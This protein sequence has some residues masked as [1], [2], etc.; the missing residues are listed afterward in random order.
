MQGQYIRISRII[1][2]VITH[3]RCVKQI[4]LQRIKF[5]WRIIVYIITQP[6]SQLH[7]LI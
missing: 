4:F 6:A 5:S 7:L 1:E 3:A 2:R